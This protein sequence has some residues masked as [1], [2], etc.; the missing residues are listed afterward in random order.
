M[1]QN[2]LFKAHLHPTMG[3]PGRQLLTW[4]GAGWYPGLGSPELGGGDP[5]HSPDGHTALCTKLSHPHDITCHNRFSGA[6]NSSPAGNFVAVGLLVGPGEP[7]FNPSPHL[8]HL[9]I[10]GLCLLW[11]HSLQDEATGV[12]ESDFTE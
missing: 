4:P 10:T 7:P 8:A 3:A 5:G 12:E 9:P 11:Y 6:E 2:V 1:V